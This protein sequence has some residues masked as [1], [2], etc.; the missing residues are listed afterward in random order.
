MIHIQSTAD[1][2]NAKQDVPVQ[3]LILRI[4]YTYEGT[5]TIVH[6]HMMQVKG[7]LNKILK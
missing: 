3:V 2:S 7:T 4:K 6:K 1:V 5:G